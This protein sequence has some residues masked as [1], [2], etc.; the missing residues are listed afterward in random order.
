M[1]C[2]DPITSAGKIF[3]PKENVFLIRN[4]ISITSQFSYQIYCDFSMYRV[5]F[6]IIPITSARK[7]SCQK[8]VYS[9]FE[10]PSASLPSSVNSTV[11]CL[12]IRFPSNALIMSV[13][14]FALWILICVG[15]NGS[16]V[17]GSLVSGLSPSNNSDTLSCGGNGLKVNGSQLIPTLL[18]NDRLL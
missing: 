3:L 8:K 13:L 11:I 4:P 17:V 18:D 9:S 12:C 15:R 10:T 6:L 7:H 14:M 1:L 2:N 5:S 16:I